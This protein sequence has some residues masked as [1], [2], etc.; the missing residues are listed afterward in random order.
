V[1]DRAAEGDETKEVSPMKKILVATD[2]SE[3]GRHALDEALGLAQASGAAVTI[4]YVR[5]APLPLLG[6]PF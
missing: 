6:D 1:P 2:G 5:H 3:R 4:V